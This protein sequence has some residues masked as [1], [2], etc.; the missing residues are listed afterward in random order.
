MAYDELDEI[1][2]ENEKKV[3]I[4][5]LKLG[6]TTASPILEKTGLQNSVFYRTIHRMIEKG[7]VSYV[8]K[9]KIKHFKAT[10]PRIFLTQIKEKEAKIRS[11][12]PNLK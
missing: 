2:T 8:L 10:D 4:E 5:L 6:E 11:I 7:V 9:G 1:L 3:Y 12:I